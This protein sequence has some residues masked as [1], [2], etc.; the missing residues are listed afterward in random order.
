MKTTI[1]LICGKPLV[2]SERVSVVSSVPSVPSLP[3]DMYPVKRDLGTQIPG[4]LE[5]SHHVLV[6]SL[7]RILCIILA[8]L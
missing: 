5:G 1:H 7:E 8:L 2:L 4:T 3:T 6:A